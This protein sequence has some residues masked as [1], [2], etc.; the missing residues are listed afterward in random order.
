MKLRRI[1]RQRKAESL[2]AAIGPPTFGLKGFS[3]L[4]CRTVFQYCG[5]RQNKVPLGPCPW[6]ARKMQSKKNIFFCSRSARR[7]TIKT[8]LMIQ[9][10]E[11]PGGYNY[12]VVNPFI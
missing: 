10:A 8:R 4:F 1:P 11:N 9:G 6:S 12:A 7:A 5:V 2:E 3:P